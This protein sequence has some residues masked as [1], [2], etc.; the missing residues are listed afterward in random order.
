MA[1]TARARAGRIAFRTTP[2][3][4]RLIER[5]VDA[6]EG[7]LS[8]VAE[9]SLLFA[10][11]RVLAERDT[12]VLAEAAA[13]EWEAI[14]ARPARE[15]ERLRRLMVRPSPSS[16]ELPATRTARGQPCSRRLHGCFLR[17]DR[18]ARTPWPPVDG[19]RHH[20][21]VRRHPDRQ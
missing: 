8:D 14:N 6:S 2:E 15:L 20:Q 7:T 19:G 10:A 3:L 11:Q 16:S 13:S 17:A 12:F 5:A 1:S 9:S 18:L 4:R 21:G